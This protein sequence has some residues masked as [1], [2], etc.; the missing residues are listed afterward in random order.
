MLD[1]IRLRI[2]HQREQELAI[3]AA[4]QINITLLRLTKGIE[5]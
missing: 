1:A 3:A 2:H 4:E 5:N